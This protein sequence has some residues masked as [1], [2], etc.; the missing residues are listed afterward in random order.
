MGKD[1]CLLNNDGLF[2]PG[3]VGKGK[4]IIV[5]ANCNSYSLDNSFGSFKIIM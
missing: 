4:Y 2:L 3:I 5:I 1:A